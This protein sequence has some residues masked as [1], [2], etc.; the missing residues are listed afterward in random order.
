MQKQL[1]IARTTE[2][3]PLEQTCHV[4]ITDAN[5]E[6]LQTLHQ[7][8]F[9][10]IEKYKLF[11]S[12]EQLTYA[13]KKP[14]DRELN[15][16]DAIIKTYFDNLKY[17]CDVTSDGINTAIYSATVAIKEHLKDI[18]YAKVCKEKHTEPKWIQNLDKIK[19]LRSNIS[20]TQLI[21]S[22]SVNS[23][24]TEHQHRICERLLYKFGNV[25]HDTIVDR[26]KLLTQELKATSLKVSYHRKNI[27][28]VRINSLFAKK[29]TIVYRS[30]RG[31][32]VQI[33]K[34]P[35]MDEVEKFWKDI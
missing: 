20:H 17:V 26:V 24:Y 19:Q 13:N 2:I 18:K 15:V 1:I 12:R 29:P 32:A 10:N 6:L 22:C 31:G 33:N 8:F 7:R 28:R 21:L 27:Q 34:M 14:S 4:T 16:T 9:E 3:P 35:S 25:K 11:D 30:F 23:S 5:N